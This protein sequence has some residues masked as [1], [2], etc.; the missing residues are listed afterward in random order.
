MKLYRQHTTQENN[1]NTTTIGNKFKK[2]DKRAK[3]S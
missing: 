1:N 2:K 3:Q